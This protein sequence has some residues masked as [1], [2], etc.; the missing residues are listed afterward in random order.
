MLSLSVL[1]FRAMLQML[2]SFAIGTYVLFVLVMLAAAYLLAP[3]DPG[4]R[5]VFALGAAQRNVSAALVVAGASFSDPA[6][7]TMV[8]LSAVV[9]LV[10][11]MAVAKVV[12]RGKA[13]LPS[14]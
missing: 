2:G 11:L 10:L 14:L 5:P 9:G 13:E 12:G 7:T 1:Q 8:L 4:T 3:R 6:I